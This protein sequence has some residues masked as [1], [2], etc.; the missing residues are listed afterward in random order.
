MS[1]VYSPIGRLIAR[2]LRRSDSDP[3]TLF[4]T[5]QAS[6]T[7][8]DWKD[9]IVQLRR[10]A[11]GLSALG[12][13]R[14]HVV[15]VVA[16]AA[17]ETSIALLG[18]L[19]L[20]LTVADL[21]DGLDTEELFDAIS[22]SSV[23]AVIV[24]SREQAESL[25]PL[26]RQVCGE[27]RLV[28]W[29]AA[30]SV[31]A[32]LPFGQVCLKGAELL[33]REPIRA[34]RLLSEAQESDIALLLPQ[35][36]RK[37][38]TLPPPGMLVVEERERYGVRLT[39]DNC[40]VAAQ[41]VI[42]ALSITS[43]DRIL[44]L[45]N[46]S[47]LV[48][49]GLLS[50]TAL[51]SGASL[52]FDAGDLSRQQRAEVTHP[53]VV[54]ADADELDALYRDIDRELLV[55]SAWRRLISSW[56]RRV[57]NEAARRRVSGFEYGLVLSCS[58]FIADQFVLSEYRRLLGGAVRR[59]ISRGARTRRS[60]RWFFEA[61]G[62]SPLGLI[63]LPES[64][65]IGLLEPPEDPRPGSY[66]RAMPGVCLCVEESGNVKIRGAFVADNAIA[67]EPSGWISLGVSGE[68]DADGTVWP[69]RTLGALDAS[70]LA[71]LPIAEHW[72]P[73]K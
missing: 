7:T 18:C 33:E 49:L 36:R 2:R 53:T 21:G 58:F 15:G 63:G 60:T 52:V 39:N 14:G 69:E 37:T 32:V 11:L 46:D 66:G 29:G 55:G 6:V 38:E 43:K 42:K 61:I 25:L 16:N 57:G 4:A 56:S 73:K 62:L 35:R 28:G 23:N 68:I 45:G 12:L 5:R 20:G 19:H 47:S 9:L 70:S 34:N 10:F 13:E 54:F 41:S 50:L 26:V 27:R 65:G 24:G 72:E 48:E 17:P 30:S 3:A 31:S 51:I 44:R 8:T 40:V 67:R 71:V 59:L 64:C 22:R 1:S